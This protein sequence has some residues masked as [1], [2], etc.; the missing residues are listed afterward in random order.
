MAVVV[1]QI[2]MNDPVY[3]VMARIDFTGASAGYHRAQLIRSSLEH[4]GE[5]WAFG[6]DYTRHWMATGIHANEIHTDITN[7]FLQMGVWG[8][9]PLLVLFALL[10]WGWLSATRCRFTYRGRPLGG[11][12]MSRLDTWGDAVRPVVNF[13][14]I[15]LFDQSVTLLYL[16]LASVGAT[17]VQVPADRPVIGAATRRSRWGSGGAPVLPA[18]LSVHGKGTVHHW[19]APARIR[20]DNA[21]SRTTPKRKP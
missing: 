10:L 20:L 19:V 6:T 13:W 11:G 3:F 18:R 7:H 15:S 21:S 4:L 5:W 16:L 17:R 9:L 2:V 8:G 1:L 12:R 14:S